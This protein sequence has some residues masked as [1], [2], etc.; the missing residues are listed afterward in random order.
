MLVTGGGGGDAYPLARAFLDA[1]PLI[2]K[3]TSLRALMMMGP[4]MPSEQREALAAQAV[5]YPVEIRCEDATHWF[6]HASA[7]LTMAGYNSL[8]EVLRWQKRA[9]VVPRSGPSAEQ[10]MRAQIFAKRRLI[11]VVEPEFL[12]PEAIAQELTELICDD[13]PCAPEMP[14]LDGAE[15]AAA[16][17]VC[18][19][20]VAASLASPKARIAL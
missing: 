8:C 7:A 14:R 5:G 2:R 3:V 9:L 16:A 11:R 20:G 6:Q 17:I 1:F 13:I 4:N 18:A 19:T 10:R 15:H 12:S